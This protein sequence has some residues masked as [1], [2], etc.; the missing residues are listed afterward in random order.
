MVLGFAC[1]GGTETPYVYLDDITI[2]CPD[3]AGG[4]DVATVLVGSG[5]GRLAAT[6]FNTLPDTSPEILFGAAVSQ[7]AAMEGGIYLNVLLGMNR[8]A[9]CALTAQGTASPTSLG[10]APPYSTPPDTNYPYIDFNVTLGDAAGRTCTKHP[11]FGTGSS[12]GVSAP[13]TGVDDP[14][15]FDNELAPETSSAPP[16]CP[17]WA[18]GTPGAQ[19]L[20]RLDAMM[21]G[22]PQTYSSSV[23]REQQANS[24]DY[25][26]ISAQ[27]I[28]G[29]SQVWLVGGFGARD[30]AMG[31]T[32]MVYDQQGETETM[33]WGEN[34]TSA[35]AEI[36]R[37][38]IESRFPPGTCF[39]DTDCT[40]GETC[41]LGTHACV[42]PEPA[43]DLCPDG[44]SE[45]GQI[46]MW[47][48][49][50]NVHLD[51]QQGWVVDADCSSGAQIA[52]LTYC[53]KFHAST[54]AVAMTVSSEAKPFTAAGGTAPTCGGVYAGP[55]Q[56]Q[57]RCCSP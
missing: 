31:P 14:V 8:Y 6:D 12:A 55:G 53:Q 43:S 39:S 17:C 21:A 35:Q 38:D 19:S 18:P 57:Y 1:F 49:K 40:P 27:T 41:D 25:S 46:A 5:P 9:S 4:T 47:S 48:G 56:S 20:A 24:Y 29:T 23:G 36:C 32:C 15:G 51:S 44:T 10:G 54:V 33:A 50:V 22:S 3:G 45:D 13:Y 26:H 11:L 42:A 2:A 30:N 16:A 34:V 7:G 37:N 28:D 52:P